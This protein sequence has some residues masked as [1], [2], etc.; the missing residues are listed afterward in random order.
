MKYTNIKEKKDYFKKVA[1]K[2]KANKSKL[3]ENVIS[4]IFDDVW[5]YKDYAKDLCRES[6]NK[7]NQKELKQ[8]LYGWE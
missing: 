8:I 7:R 3:I 5:S 1:E 4:D 6:L 2:R